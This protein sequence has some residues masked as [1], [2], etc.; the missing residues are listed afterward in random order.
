MHADSSP[1][2]TDPIRLA[3]SVLHVVA[4]WVSRIA[5]PLV[6]GMLAVGVVTSASSP[7][8]HAWGWAATYLAIVVG[9]PVLYTLALYSR[10]AVNDLDLTARHE[11]FR[12]YL[13]TV[14]A[15]IGAALLLHLGGAPRL[16]TLLADVSAIELAV[17]FAI[18]L[19]WKISAH[20]AMAAMLAMLATH[21]HATLAPMGIALVLVVCWSRVYLERHDVAQTVAGAAV[22][23]GVMVAA[24]GW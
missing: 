24:L 17:L 14:I 3:P 16:L 19:V 6:L 8:P 11:R 5:S 15:L 18:T 7:A 12:P 1:M 22:G 21:L 20:A 23:A 4:I 2:P 10:G 9:T 13:V